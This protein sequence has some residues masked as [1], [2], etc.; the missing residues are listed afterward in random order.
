MDLQKLPQPVV[1]KIVRLEQAQAQVKE[2]EAELAEFKEQLKEAMLEA[3]KTK[4]DLPGVLYATLAERATYKAEDMKR[5]PPRLRKLTLDTQAVA[6]YEGLYGKLPEPITK[7]T[8]T[9]LARFIAGGK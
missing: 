4:V 5:V 2:L 9:Y 6:K 7:S 3:G 1:D 8:T